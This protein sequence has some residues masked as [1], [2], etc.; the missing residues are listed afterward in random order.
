MIRVQQEVR[1]VWSD[2][3]GSWGCGAYLENKWFQLRWKD[4]PAAVVW[5]AGWRG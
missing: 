4:Y 1:Q 3:S 5:G 2:A